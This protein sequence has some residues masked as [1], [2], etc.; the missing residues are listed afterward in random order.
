VTVELINDGVHVVA[1]AARMLRELVPGRIALITDAMAATGMSDGDYM[2]GSLPVRV[3]DSV[4]RLV[5]ADGAVGPIAEP[6]L[7]RGE[8]VRRAV[9]EVGMSPR[10]AVQPA[11]L[12]PLRALGLTAERTAGSSADS[13]LAPG[14]P[15]D[16][17][18]L[19]RD[20]SIRRTWYSH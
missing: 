6:S 2:L 19:D 20:M 17:L 5:T 11:G 1:P 15:A 8:A 4:A 10:E 13:R 9:T 7:T 12:V 14:M 3:E 18:L 16:L